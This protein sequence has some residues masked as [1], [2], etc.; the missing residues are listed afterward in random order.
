LMN[1][2]EMMKSPDTITQLTLKRNA[3]LADILSIYG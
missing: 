1:E 2:L 3:S